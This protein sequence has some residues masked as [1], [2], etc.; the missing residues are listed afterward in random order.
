MFL[1]QIET[2]SVMSHVNEYLPGIAT[3]KNMGRIHI[4]LL[5]SN[6]SYMNAFRHIIISPFLL[7]AYKLCYVGNSH[8]NVKEL[9]FLFFCICVPFCR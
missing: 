5:L 8:T 2:H 4:Y 1:L 6:V 9:D 7:H 3:N